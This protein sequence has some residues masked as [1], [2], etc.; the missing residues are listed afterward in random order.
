[1][2]RFI[3]GRAKTGKTARIFQSIQ[4]AVE[5]KIPGQYLIVPEQYSH[6]AERELCKACGD[7]L[8]LYAEVL[9]FTAFARRIA[10]EMGG[11]AVPYLDKGGKMLCM[12]LAAKLSES[13][14]ELFRSAAHRPELQSTLL[15]VN[16]R[17]KTAG[18]TVEQLL[19]AAENCEGE[20][21]KKLQDL[22]L[23]AE[24]YDA[25][26]GNSYA[27][28]ADRLSVLARQI[29]GSSLG[30]KNTVYIDGFLD[31]TNT[32]LSVLYELLKKNV[33]L[34]VCLTMDVHNANNEIFALSRSSARKLLAMAKELGVPTEMIHTEENKEENLP[35]LR[36]FAERLFSY[37][38]MKQDAQG[39]IELYTADHL[40][41]ECEFAAAKAWE[42]VRETGCRWKDIAVAIRGFEEYAPTL[43][44]IFEE[45]DVP[46][47]SANKTAIISRPLPSLIASAYAIVAGEWRVDDVLGYMDT[48][49]T[50]LTRE[51]C[52]L[53]AEYIYRWK[54]TD[55]AWHSS[56]V[57][58]QHPDGYGKDYD[59]GTEQRLQTIHDIRNQLSAPLLALEEATKTAKTAAQ[60][61]QAL[62]D[63]LSALHM[64]ERLEAKAEEF[65]REGRDALAEE[66][67]Q[68]WDVMVNALEQVH[69]VLGEKPMKRDE[70]VRLFLVTL[71]QYDVGIIPAS[72]DAVTAGD[73]DRMRRRNIR[74]LIVLG[75]TDARLPS[76]MEDSGI[77]SDDE[78]RTLDQLGAG[79]GEHP[80][81]EMWREYATVYHCLSLPSE[82]LILCCPLTDASGAL[83][84]PSLVMTRAA[85]LFELS[86]QPVSE[87]VSRCAAV[88]PALLLAASRAGKEGAAA[89]RYFLQKAPG[90][91][92]KIRYAASG[93]RGTLTEKSVEALYGKK[94][95]ISASRADRF[96]SCRCAYFYQYGLKIRPH[97]PSEFD[98]AE[99]GTFTHYVLQHTADDIKSA[100]GFEQVEDEQILAFAETYIRQYETEILHGLE[101]K[102]ARFRYLFHRSEQNIRTIV[103][104]MAHELKHSAFV[105]LAFE[106]NFGDREKFP[107]IR[108]NNG[109]DEVNITGIADRVDGW[110]H[111][112]TLYL[113]VDDYK[114]GKKKFSLSDI[115]YGL[116]M[117][118]LLYLY[119]LENGGAKMREALGIA[120]NLEL[121]AAGIEYIPAR[122]PLLPLESNS[123]KDEAETKRRKELRRT[124]LVLSDNGVLNAWDHSEQKIYTPAECGKSGEPKEGSIATEEQFALLYGLIQRRL[125][126][127]AEQI[128]A[129]SIEAD[130]YEKKP[131]ENPCGYCD[132][133]G[134]CGFS[135]GENGEQY[136]HTPK[137]ENE[138]IWEKIREEA[139]NHG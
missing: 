43:E 64:A 85:A 103:L 29:A 139:E 46:L 115:W 119:S 12:A 63:Y 118:M 3:I 65:C 8:S 91:M 71:S 138:E 101:E 27:D 45:Y 109:K 13:R 37:T 133:S 137:L 86:I 97:K 79:L 129:G 95:S 41:A 74:F 59:E 66:Y 124:G 70:F 20:L 82:K 42:L 69:A 100:G 78:L 76:A 35:P 92:E 6:E 16:D 38:E 56:R 135:D 102:N 54:L 67:R 106:L 30:E 127:M 14:L 53:L 51:E 120:D 132:F 131:G 113:R 83:T 11:I 1:M 105:P 84:R 111:D 10:A 126:A 31:F 21:Q 49:L 9:S 112:G 15:A 121:K 96:Y 80:D 107:P 4:S 52:D 24:A 22:A 26:L 81:V 75:A 23:I 48:G 108:M 99:L 128:R 44:S 2:L 36:C 19:H 33:T 17:V 5:K 32:E 58:H 93:M 62:A 89:E 110:E 57:W 61:A 104:D 88:R 136:R 60:Q 68:L 50:G 73:F 123:G 18:V 94:I 134:R 114:T 125:G 77:F 47:F 55:S 116:S 87:A 98:S 34:T 72:L 130:P 7:T 25:I 39:Q 90:K 122:D 40:T 117:Q 28:P